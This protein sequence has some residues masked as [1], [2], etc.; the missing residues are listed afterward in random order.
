MNSSSAVSATGM[1]GIMCSNTWG[2]PD[3][4]RRVIKYLKLGSLSF[5]V[6]DMLAIGSGHSIKV[7]VMG[8]LTVKAA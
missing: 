2:H 7:Q 3:L 4:E 1:S 8:G 6:G 5:L